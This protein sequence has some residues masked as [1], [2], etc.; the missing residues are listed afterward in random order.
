MGQKKDD[1][2]ALDATSHISKHDVAVDAPSRQNVINTQGLTQKR[3][4]NKNT[5]SAIDSKSSNEVNNNDLYPDEE[6]TT[7]ET[8]VFDD[9]NVSED[10]QKNLDATQLYLG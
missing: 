8:D 3:R 6:E 2:V 9:F 4:A 5:I 10:V 1:I 7:A